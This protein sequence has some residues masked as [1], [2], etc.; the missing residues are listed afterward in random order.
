LP[1]LGDEPHRLRRVVLHLPTRRSRQ[2]ANLFLR[3]PLVQPHI[4]IEAMNLN[5]RDRNFHAMLWLILIILLTWSGWHPADR[6]TWFLEVVPIFIISVVLLSVYQ[7]FYFSRLVCC[8]M[9]VHAAVLS[10]GGH[11]TYAQVPLFNWIRDAFHL[12]RNSYDRVGHFMQGFVPA[13]ISREVLLRRGVLKRGPWLSF[14]IVCICLA[15]SAT[16]ELFEWQAAVWTGEKADAFL[17]SQGDPWDTQNDMA[18]ALIG[19]LAAVV[20]LPHRHDRSMHP[21]EVG[22]SPEPKITSDI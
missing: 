8:L 2:N 7:S 12:A 19:S 20:L 14:I 13:L 22:Q 10:I 9:L 17:G 5:T 15:I 16:Y 18:L 1:L 3:S 6:F 21:L 4:G 11:Y